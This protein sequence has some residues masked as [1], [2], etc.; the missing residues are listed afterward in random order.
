MDPM[1]YILHNHPRSAAHYEPIHAASGPWMPHPL[2]SPAYPWQSHGQGVPQSYPHHPLQPGIPIPGSDPFQLTPNGGLPPPVPGYHGGPPQDAFAGAMPTRHFHHS[3]HRSSVP[4]NITGP[5]NHFGPHGHVNDGAFVNQVPGGRSLGFQPPIGMGM[6]P[7]G[8]SSDPHSLPRPPFS[9]NEVPPNNYPHHPLFVP[10][11]PSLGP[12]NPTQT[13]RTHFHSSSAS[14]R[15]YREVTS[16]NRPSQSASSSR[17]SHPRS[18]RSMSARF[19]T[20]EL[21][22]DEEEE[23]LGRQLFLDHIMQSSGEPTTTSMDQHSV[24]NVLVRQIQLVRGAVSSK[25]VAS[26]MTIR[27]LQSVDIDDLPETEKTCVI[28]YNDYGVETPEGINEAPLR[29]PNCK[30]VFGDHCIKKWLEDSDSCPYCRDKLHAEPKQ[31]GSSARAFMNM[32]RMRAGNIP[33]G[34]NPDDVVRRALSMSPADSEALRSRQTSSGGRRLPPD[35]L[36]EQQRRTRPRHGNFETRVPN[37]AS[38]SVSF[39][40]PSASVASPLGPDS[41]AANQFARTSQRSFPSR[42]PPSQPPQPQR[43]AWPGAVAGAPARNSSNVSQRPGLAQPSNSM[44]PSAPSFFPRAEFRNMMETPDISPTGLARQQSSSS[45]S[46]LTS[47]SSSSSS[48]SSAPPA[49]LPN[50]LQSSDDVVRGG[51]SDN[52]NASGLRSNV[53]NM[54]GGI[55]ETNQIQATQNN[56]NRPW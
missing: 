37:I 9:L 32:M 40:A 5:G 1:D 33:P 29:L 3:P 6:P 23:E 30:H 48:S 49:R 19:L 47:V 26:K 24:D 21:S 50:P 13:R 25:M 22:R 18:R 38:Q 17:R 4:G 34:T 52:T 8:N 31:H 15:P 56:R 41:L 2:P 39:E 12:F 28:C 55:G 20:S 53:S 44:S 51:Q 54:Q 14:S 16:P 10:P 35:D 7:A 43:R 11:P 46:S 36:A 42:P 45:S 27:S